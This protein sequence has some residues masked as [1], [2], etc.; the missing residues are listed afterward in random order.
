LP[1]PDEDRKATLAAYRN[2]RVMA[3]A[4]SS[5]LNTLLWRDALELRN[6][7][8]ASSLKTLKDANHLLQAL[9]PDAMFPDFVSKDGTVDWEQ[10]R[11][12]HA[13]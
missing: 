5:A 13:L 4:A 6:A 8:S 2:F 3:L 1:D 11:K 7:F 10:L 12:K 9:P